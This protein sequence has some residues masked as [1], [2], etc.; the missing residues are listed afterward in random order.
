VSGYGGDEAGARG[1]G[2]DQTVIKASM[3]HKTMN[4]IM[5]KE[6][7]TMASS[8]M[9]NPSTLLPKDLIH[10]VDVSVA[11]KYGANLISAINPSPSG[12]CAEYA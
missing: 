9:V 4:D 12:G 1:G 3:L 8:S 11:T 10:S 5:Q 6:E 7:S 2:G